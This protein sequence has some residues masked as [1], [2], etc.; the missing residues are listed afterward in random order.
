MNNKPPAAETKQKPCVCNIFTRAGLV[1]K[2]T[3]QQNAQRQS[4]YQCKVCGKTVWRTA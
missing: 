4:E 2:A 3:G 1:W